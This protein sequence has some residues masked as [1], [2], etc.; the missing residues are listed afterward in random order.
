MFTDKNKWQVS[1]NFSHIDPRKQDLNRGMQNK[2]E[3]L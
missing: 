1:F 2:V 3:S